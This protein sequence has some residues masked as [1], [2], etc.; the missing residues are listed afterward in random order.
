MKMLSNMFT[1]HPLAKKLAKR[2]LFIV[3]MGVA[4][5]V[6]ACVCVVWLIFFVLLIPF[7]LV[8]AVF[9]FKRSLSDDTP[10][11]SC[12]SL[13]SRQNS[14]KC[15]SVF[16]R[17]DDISKLYGCNT[18]NVKYRWKIF[19]T[20]LEVIKS[21]FEEFNALDYGAGSLRDSYEL[22]RIGFKVI[23]ADLDEDL[24]RHYFQSY[25]W[26]RAANLPKLFV[27]TL[28]SLI[29]QTGRHSFRLVTAFDV[30]EHLEDP[31]GFL[32][33][34]YE[35][36]HD[37]GYIFCTVPNRFSIFERYFRYQLEKKRKKGIPV[38]SGVPHVQFK[39]PTE[40][41]EFFEDNE[42][43]IVEHDMAIGFFVNDC[44][45]GLFGLPIRVFVAPILTI[46]STKLHSTLTDIP[47]DPVDFE[48][49][50]YPAWL[51]ERVNV[52]D[53]FF[54]RWLSHR[55][56]WNLIV[57]QKMISPAGCLFDNSIKAENA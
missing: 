13:M 26:D 2:V 12:N 40:W 10:V 45:H 42:F 38:K 54:K 52:L 48:R 1:S 24:L 28:P 18:R 20:W 49:S 19:S 25:N 53:M 56:G 51:M 36:L 57:A 16:D 5:F 17:R 23:S 55:F 43:R 37:R 39:S 21:E 11:V 30:I 46:L 29:E 47:F 41:A 50:F 44:W 31:A 35:L 33:Y 27:G 3:R 34:C 32:H 4:I 7:L 6:L 22:A 9:D 14:T 15:I 8:E